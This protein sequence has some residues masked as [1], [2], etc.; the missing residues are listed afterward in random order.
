MTVKVLRW[1][2]RPSYYRLALGEM[3][4]A[5]NQSFACVS[6]SGVEQHMCNSTGSTL[7]SRKINLTSS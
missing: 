5:V 7:F 4:R 1:H 3:R 6:I 2:Q